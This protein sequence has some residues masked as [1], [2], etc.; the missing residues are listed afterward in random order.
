MKMNFL[1]EKE[2]RRYFVF[3]MC[4]CALLFGM[5]LVAGSIQA[6]ATKGALL[7][8][9]QA[10]V[11]SLLSW[12]VPVDVVAAAYKNEEITEEG[13][14]FLVRIGWSAKTDPGLL[15]AVRQRA[16]AFLAFEVSTAFGMSLLLVF[17]AIGFLKRREV[18]YQEAVTVIEGFAAGDFSHHLCRDREGTLYQ[19]FGA[20]D[21]LS[22]ALKA[23]GEA[24]LKAKEALKEAIS[25]ISHQLKTPLAALCMYTEIM[26]NEPDNPEAVRRFSHKSLQAISGMDMLIQSLLKVMRLDAGAVLFEKKSCRVSELVLTAAQELR[27]R[28]EQEKKQFLQEGDADALLQCDLTWTAQALANLIKNALDH[29]AAG[30][31]IRIGWRRSQTMLRLWVA[32]DGCGISPEDMPHIFKRF[33]RSR[34]SADLQ[35]CGLGLALAKSIVEGQGGVLSAVSEPEQGAVFTITFLTEM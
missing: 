34:N 3:L 14:D 5:A 32:D 8:R 10:V 16:A 13:V 19:M 31:T 4:F 7:E 17:K 30:G 11:S 21:Q 2:A 6:Q 12:G 29:T 22:K 9:E 23:K 20:V 25:D 18:Q 35:G 24:E 15:P 26:L 28:A 1:N 33:Y 27:T